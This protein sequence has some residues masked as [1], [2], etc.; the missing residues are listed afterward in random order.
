[1]ET[2]GVHATKPNVVA[3]IPHFHALGPK[4][5][6]EIAG[7]RRVR[8][9]NEDV[10]LATLLGRDLQE[11]ALDICI[12][13]GIA[14]KSVADPSRRS[15]RLS[16]AFDRQI[17]PS[18]DWPSACLP[19]SSGPTEHIHSVAQPAEFYCDATTDAASGACD[20]GHAGGACRWQRECAQRG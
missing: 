4:L 1:M 15:H 14:R 6:S 16:G 17:K 9:A 8:R 13:A 3:R 2:C 10:D 18:C 19:T 12:V 20:Y 7:R 11:R 5:A